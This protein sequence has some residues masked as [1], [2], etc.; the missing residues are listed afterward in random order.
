MLSLSHWSLR[1]A[2]DRGRAKLYEWRHPGVPWLTRQAVSHLDEFLRS[3]HTGLEWGAGRSTAWIAARVRHLV[4]VE[5]DSAW[6]AQVRQSLQRRGLGNVTLRLLDPESPSYTGVATDMDDGTL[7]FA[8]VDGISEYRDRCALA[9]LP[10]IR[11]R[12]LVIVDDIHRYLPSES[13]APLSLGPARVPL[14]PA[15]ADFASHVAAWDLLWTSDG[16][17]DTAIWRRPG[18]H[19]GL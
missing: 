16:V 12:G 2:R 9:V 1:Y 19:P 18:E 7:D 15:W 8:L 5:T 14:T 11:P 3:A 17:R 10:K 6:C 13:R 4:S